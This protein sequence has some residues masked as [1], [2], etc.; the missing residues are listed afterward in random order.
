MKSSLLDNIKSKGYWRVNFQPIVEEIIDLGKC[1]EY[2]EQ[3]SINLTGWDYPHIPNGNN[4]TSGIDIDNNYY[5]EWI[6][7]LSNGRLEFWKMFQSTQ[8]IHYFGLLEDW[9]PGR[10]SS[11]WDNDIEAKSGEMLGVTRTIYF[12]TSVFQFLSRLGNNGLYK[13]GVEVN[14]SL[15]NTKGRRLI[16]DHQARFPFSVPRITDAESIIT[17]SETYSFAEVTEDPN[18]LALKN[19]IYIF[20]RF[21]WDPPNVDVIKSDQENLI[22]GKV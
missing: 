2:V 17:P 4:E 18:G 13:Q 9:N 6:E 11:L 10:Y 5:Q 8:F 20:K 16:V 1:R 19:I 14:I 21:G 15:H 7:V 12:I 22:S 3:S